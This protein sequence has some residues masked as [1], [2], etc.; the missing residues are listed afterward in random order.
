[1]SDEQQGPD[2]RRL[3][4]SQLVES[5]SMS[6]DDLRSRV[7]KINRILL[8]RTFVA[9]LLLLICSGFFGVLLT[10]RAS[11]LV[12]QTDIEMA[13]C[14]FLV[15]AGCCCWQLMSLLRRA[16]VKS[17]TEGEPSACAAFY[18]AE[19]ERQR[20]FYRR[21]AVWVP[22]ALSALCVWVLLLIPHFTVIMIVIWVLFVPFYIYQNIELARSSQRELDNLNTSFQ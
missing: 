21:S 16:R 6:L 1:M 12:T 10:L 2:V 9:G 15:G 19:L 13:Q 18:R 20:S 4:Q 7:A 8:T 3:W 5:T 11:T 22:L 14:V 17:L